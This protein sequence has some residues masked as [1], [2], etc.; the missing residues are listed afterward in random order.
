MR[1]LV[2]TNLFLDVLLDRKD[3]AN[4]S[5]TVLDWCESHPGSGWI[6]WHTLANL[7]YI[8]ARQTSPREAAQFID[9]ILAVFD[10]CPTDSATARRARTLNMA[11]FEDALQAAAAQNADLNLIV[12]RNIRDFRNSPIP[13]HTPPQFIRKYLT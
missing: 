13:A 3:L 2:D 9:D 1:I 5:Q 8:G 7:Y 11:D 12:T 4:E 10:V 6:A